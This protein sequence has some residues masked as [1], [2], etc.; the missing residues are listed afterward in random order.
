MAY[1]LKG[2]RPEA[3]QALRKSVELNPD[4][5][6]KGRL[7]AALAH[8]GER[9]EAQKLLNELIA[10]SGRRYVQGYYVATAQLA[11]GDKDGA[12]ASLEGDVR[13]RS[14]Y[15]MWLA[16]IRSSTASAAIRA[17]PRFWKR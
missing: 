7:A 16:I 9:A 3:I 13:E 11:L 2:M 5:V 6:T 4:D 17:L 12:L 8:A 15:M 14:I 1:D 10:E